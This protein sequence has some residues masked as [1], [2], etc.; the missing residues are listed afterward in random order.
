MADLKDGEIV[1]ELTAKLVGAESLKWNPTKRAENQRTPVHALEASF[2]NLISAGYWNAASE[3]AFDAARAVTA[4]DRDTT[5]RVFEALRANLSGINPSFVGQPASSYH[6]ALREQSSANGPLSG[7]GPAQATATDSVRNSNS[8]HCEPRGNERPQ[9]PG[10]S[11]PSP[12]ELKL[13]EWRDEWNDS[14]KSREVELIS[15][16]F[17]LPSAAFTSPPKN[18]TPAMFS[19]PSISPE[20]FAE[21]SQEPHGTSQRPQIRQEADDD[22]SSDREDGDLEESQKQ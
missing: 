12:L 3:N 21:W 7:F 9:P 13:N 16:S 14:E 1:C 19:V 20:I 11:K 2:K 5:L 17:H 4:G 6:Q 18:D 8:A 10:S 22:A 15:H